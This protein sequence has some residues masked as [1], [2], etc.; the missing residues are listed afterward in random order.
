M[1]YIYI[2]FIALMIMTSC[3]KTIELELPEYESKLVVECYLEP[4]KPFSCLLQ[5]SVE[6]TS[7]PGISLVN[8]AIVIIQHNGIFDTLTPKPGSID[9]LTGRASN[10]TSSAMMTEDYISAYTL[11]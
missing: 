10:Y 4:G 5:E 6:F 9:L 7:E 3:S 1:K 11:Y 2:I 8:D